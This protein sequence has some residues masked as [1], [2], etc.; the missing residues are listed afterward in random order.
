MSF[1]ALTLVI[2]LRPTLAWRL[3]HCPWTYLS[4]STA[5]RDHGSALGRTGLSA[6]A[7]AAPQSA[8]PQRARL[9]LCGD[10]TDS[11]ETASSGPAF[12]D[13]QERAVQQGGYG[14]SA[15]ALDALHAAEDLA[16]VSA[17]LETRPEL[18]LPRFYVLARPEKI[19]VDQVEMVLRS[20]G[21]ALDRGK[22]FTVLWDLRELKIPPRAVIRVATDWMGQPENAKRLDRQARATAVVVKGPLIRACA[23]WTLAICKPP[24]PVRICRDRDEALE[25][26]RA[27]HH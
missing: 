7:P 21:C 2:L 23:S 9:V 15:P 8:R 24:C 3:Q 18:A 14:H 20:L 27:I 1:S 12:H 22:E 26:A 17:G 10:R 25:F 4:L 5:P 13:E 6:A 11:T 19:T 16:C